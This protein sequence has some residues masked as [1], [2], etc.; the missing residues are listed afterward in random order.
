MIVQSSYQ[1]HPGSAEPPEAKIVGINRTES[2][3]YLELQVRIGDRDQSVSLPLDALEDRGLSGP[4]AAEA[5]RGIQSA[6]EELV[7]GLK[8]R[9]ETG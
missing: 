5:L 7:R 3:S 8:G 6:L 2:S 1:S 4:A 9:Q